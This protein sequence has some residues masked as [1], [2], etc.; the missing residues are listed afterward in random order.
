MGVPK[1]SHSKNLFVPKDNSFSKKSISITANFRI[2][3]FNMVMVINLF[4][5]FINLS[6]LFFFPFLTMVYTDYVN[7]GQKV[8]K[9]GIQN[10]KY[11]WQ[12]I[13]IIKVNHCTL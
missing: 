6:S 8:S 2:I 10:Q 7:I 4:K 1:L 11:F 12:E 5:R 3:S 13:N 9:R